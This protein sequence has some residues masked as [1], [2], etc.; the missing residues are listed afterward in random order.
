MVPNQEVIS[1]MERLEALGATA[2]LET[3]IGNCRL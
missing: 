2:I 1:A 3:K